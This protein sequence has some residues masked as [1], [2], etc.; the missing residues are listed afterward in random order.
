[1]MLARDFIV[2]YLTFPD[3]KIEVGCGAVAVVVPGE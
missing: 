2:R 3:L 1:M